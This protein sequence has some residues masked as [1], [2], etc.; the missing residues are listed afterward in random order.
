MMELVERFV[1]PLQVD[2]PLWRRQIPT[3]TAISLLGKAKITG[4]LPTLRLAHRIENK[5][6]RVNIDPRRI[7]RK[8][9]ENLVTQQEEPDAWILSVSMPGSTCQ[10]S[11]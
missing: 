9:L 3:T 4:S 6:I 2:R 5:E 11:V 1:S 10:N 8:M 7:P